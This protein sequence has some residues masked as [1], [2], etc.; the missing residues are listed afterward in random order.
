MLETEAGRWPVDKN[1]CCVSL[2]ISVQML[3]KPT[4][5]PRHGQ[6]TLSLPALGSMEEGIVCGMS[7]H[8]AVFDMRASSYHLHILLEQ[9]MLPATQHMGKLGH[10]AE[11]RLNPVLGV[12]HP[13]SPIS[14]TAHS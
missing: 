12:Q 4:R 1:T 2:R 8:A 3:H 10:R 11:T 7:K 9:K 14:P 13:G 6:M 5:K